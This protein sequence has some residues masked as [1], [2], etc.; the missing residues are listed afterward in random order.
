MHARRRRTV[1]MRRFT[2][3]VCAGATIAAVAAASGVA[4]GDPGEDH[5]HDAI[6]VPTP[7]Q[8]LTPPGAH[9]WAF[10]DAADKDGV[11]NSD[12]AFYK[13]LAFAGNYDG[14][15]IISIRHPDAL[16]V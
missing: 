15:R 8:P 3:L 16:Q 1:H 14:F 12:I 9:G 4:L 11:T 10:L 6:P 7:S 13:D 5:G 2:R